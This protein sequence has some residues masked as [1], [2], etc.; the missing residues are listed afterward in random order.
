M[1]SQI[2]AQSSAA[3][4]NGA[5]IIVTDIKS[6]KDFFGYIISRQMMSENDAERNTAMNQL[7]NVSSYF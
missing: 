5:L 4:Q 2:S 1:T 7:V 6:G 3:V